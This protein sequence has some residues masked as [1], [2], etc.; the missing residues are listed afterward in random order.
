MSLRNLGS[1]ERTLLNLYSN[2]QLGITPAAFYA[3]WNVTH[4]QMARICGCSESTVN[5]WF[6]QG[7]GN[8]PP[9]PIYLRRLAEMD[10]LW[11]HYEQIPLELRQQLCRSNRDQTL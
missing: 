6:Q 1:R 10:F 8:Q 7:R 4:A 2:C 3:K 11:N 5:R 9:E